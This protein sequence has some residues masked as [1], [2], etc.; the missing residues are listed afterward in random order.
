MNSEDNSVDMEDIEGAR[1][2]WNPF[3]GV[4]GAV[5][6]PRGKS[7]PFTTLDQMSIAGNIALGNLK[8]AHRLA[9]H[10]MRKLGRT[11]V[12]GT[13]GNVL[14]RIQAALESEPVLWAEFHKTCVGL[15]GNVKLP[16]AVYAEFPVVTCPGAGGYS[17]RYVLPAGSMGHAV[18]SRAD[19]TGCVQWCYSLKT[20]GKPSV[21]FSRCMTTLGATVN[22]YK[23]AE[24]VLE[25][26]SQSK[27]RILRLFVDGDIR[28]E[29]HLD[30]WMSAIRNHPEVS[31]Y[32]YSKSWHLF[33]NYGGVWPKNYRVNLSSG[34]RFEHDNAL[35][36]RLLSLPVVRG[37]FVAV[38]PWEQAWLYRSVKDGL[39]R[40]D[41]ETA[42][43]QW[44]KECGLL[45][46]EAS[47]MKQKH[48]EQ[49]AQAKEACDR[50][51]AKRDQLESHLRSV[52]PEFVAQ[53]RQMMAE[54]GWIA[55]RSARE[56]RAWANSEKT[57]YSPGHISQT[58][59]FDL[60]KNRLLPKQQACP[61]AC[62]TCPNESFKDKEGLLR[63]FRTRDWREV[64]KLSERENKPGERATHLCF[65]LR[66]KQDIL[67]AY[68]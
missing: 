51:L 44:R 30:A 63:A 16:F 18:A 15:K 67:I 55:D 52:D 48:G 32:G 12:K 6:N 43:A 21:F 57:P 62:S 9:S 2:G 11:E 58:V 1:A 34:S 36:E 38:D 37:R 46:I 17:S 14:K 33:D 64:A 20:A 45:E 7:V 40:H 42:L 4:V 27:A 10:F 28:S 39:P 29:E 47:L 50:W 61:I 8:E 66:G 41:A 24:I 5:E 54:A 35:K 59:L 13:F 22:P 31:V 25:K 65:G 56:Y 60:V 19:E 53:A 26:V 49:S 68:H 23:A 3:S